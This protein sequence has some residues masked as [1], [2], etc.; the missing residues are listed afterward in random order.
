VLPLRGKRLEGGRLE[1]FRG[2]VRMGVYVA[3]YGVGEVHNYTAPAYP[4]S[5]SIPDY[6]VTSFVVRRGRK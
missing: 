6:G 3:V 4:V 5:E 2:N 1:D